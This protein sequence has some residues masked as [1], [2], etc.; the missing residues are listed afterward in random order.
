MLLINSSVP[1]DDA[2]IV[3]LWLSECKNQSLTEVTPHILGLNVS[4]NN[5][6]INRHANSQ[7]KAFPR[8]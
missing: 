6:G 2:H 7:A 3:S 1:E 5:I 8:H 4:K